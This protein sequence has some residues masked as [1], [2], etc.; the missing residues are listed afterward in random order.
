MTAL[1]PALA[2]ISEMGIRYSE[3]PGHT[4]ELANA[5]NDVLGPRWMDTRGIRIVSI[6][7]NS[8]KANEE[9]EE[10]IKQLQRTAV[11]RNPGMAAAHLARAQG[12]AM[13]GAANNENAGVFAA[14]A[15]LNMVQQAGGMQAAQLFNLAGAQQPQAAPQPPVQAPAGAQTSGQPAKPVWQCRCGTTNSSAFCTECGSAKPA[16][17]WTCA[18]GA[19]NRGKFCSECGKP[20]PADAPLYACDKCGW[21][22]EDKHNPPKFCPECGDA[23]DENDRK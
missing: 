23:F 13:V 10:M 2:K 21:E 5:L 19:T 16:D 12:E 1:Q 9:D 17:G 7:V 22:P 14:F 18:C 15:G 4:M 8:V 20:K 11:L 6:G 3:L